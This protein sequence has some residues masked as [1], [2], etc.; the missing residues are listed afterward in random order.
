MPR[1]TSVKKA[2]KSPGK[3]GKCGDAIGEGQPYVWWA[4]R[5]G[6][7]RIRCAKPE[8]APKG[9]DLTQSE[10][11]ST[12]YSI[13]EDAKLDGST[14]EE[15]EGQRDDVVSQL[16]DLAE[17]TRGKFENMPDGLQQG[18]TGQLLEERADACES[19]AQELESVD[20]DE[21]D[22][23]EGESDDDFEQRK[24]EHLEEVQTELTDALENISI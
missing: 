22:R 18:D 11:Y 6:G 23:E 3:C 19:A 4:F 16:N 21:I 17:E 2:Q 7:K 12:L 5:Y 24:Q 20:C 9:S 13:Q 10:F 15:L 1:V 8:C 14:V